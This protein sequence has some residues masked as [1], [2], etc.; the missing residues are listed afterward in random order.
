MDQ[1]LVRGEALIGQSKQQNWAK[2]FQEGFEGVLQE[3]AVNRAKD[4]AEKKAINNRVGNYINQLNSDLDLTELMPSQNKAVKDYLV[5]NRNKYASYASEIAKIE[6]PSD[7]RYL[8]LVD[9]M[10]GIKR[11]FGNLAGQVKN[12]KQDKVSYLKDFDDKRISN[13]NTIG[14]LGAAANLYTE[15]GGMS[16]GEG[17]QLLFINKD[18]NEYANYS[19]L[20]KPFLKDFKAADNLLKLNET[21]YKSGQSLSGARKNM[22]RNRLKNMINSGGRDTLLSLASDDFLIEGGLNLQDPSIFEPGNEDLLSRKVLD[23]YM[24]ALSDTATQG[25]A[26]KRPAT[27]SGGS[28]FSGALNDEIRL[29]EPVVARDAVNF[30]SIANIK[31]TSQQTE[32]KTQAIVQ[33]I[34]NIDPT[35]N[36]RPYISRGQMFDYFTEAGDY[37]SREEAVTQFKKKYGNAQIFKFNPTYAGESRPLAVNVNNPR[38]LYDL[39]IQSSNLSSKAANYFRGQFDNY[40]RSS[41]P[42]KSKNNKSSSTRGGSLD[43]L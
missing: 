30:A 5:E 8:E 40:T 13:G 33:A 31:A 25:A 39:Y 23:S 19:S 32:Q 20:Q 43:N 36:E 35:S 7:S 42:S 9:K 37:D 28:G 24:D 21:V 17:G 16:V 38:E 27:R 29:A 10:N 41:E 22:I 14:S 26:D 12:F 3:V 2:S 1:G 34:N 4:L 6:D 18:K 11:S 15:D